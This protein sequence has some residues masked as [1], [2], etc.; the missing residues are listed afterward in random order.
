VG[1]ADRKAD[2]TVGALAVVNDHPVLSVEEQCP[3]GA[4]LD[5]L[6]AAAAFVDAPWVVARDAI[7]V[8]PLHEDHKTVARPI[9]RTEPRYL[10]DVPLNYFHH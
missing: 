7:E 2:V 8:A 6:A 10:I 9:D 5:A 4:W 1:W 3:L